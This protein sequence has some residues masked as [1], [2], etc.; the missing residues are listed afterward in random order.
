MTDSETVALGVGIDTARYGHHV[1]FLRE[2]LQPA[3][4]VLEVPES[5]E[6]YERLR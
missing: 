3:T 6:G 5:R 4:T 2:D 1:T